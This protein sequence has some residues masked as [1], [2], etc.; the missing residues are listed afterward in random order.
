[1]AGQHHREHG[2]R[3]RCQRF[4]DRHAGQCANQGREAAP[5]EARVIDKE[6]LQQGAQ[7]FEF[8]P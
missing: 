2:R 1:M 6:D 5:R 7:R 3:G 4:N 8:T